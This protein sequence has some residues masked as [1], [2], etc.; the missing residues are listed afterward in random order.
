MAVLTLCNNVTISAP[1]VVAG[2]LQNTA[3]LA[4]LPYNL[5]AKVAGV[6]SPA[7]LAFEDSPDS[8]NWAPLFV[9][10]YE[11]VAGG[12]PGPFATTYQISGLVTTGSAPAVRINVYRATSSFVFSAQIFY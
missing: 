8:V 11:P 10:D 4:G 3:A 7:R 5:F 2:S 12:A 6:T 1:N 9:L